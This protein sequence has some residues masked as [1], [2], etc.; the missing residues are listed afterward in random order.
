MHGITDDANDNKNNEEEE[1]YH[2]WSSRLETSMSVPLH[3]GSLLASA[4]WAVHP[5]RAEVI[6]W[7][8]CQPY[9]LAGTWVLLGAFSY[10]QWL[11]RVLLTPIP[12]EQQGRSGGAALEAKG[13]FSLLS[14]IGL[15]VPLVC[16]AAAV[17]SKAAALPFPAMLVA[18]DFALAPLPL[19]SEGS[20]ILMHPSQSHPSRR[21]CRR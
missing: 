13:G 9:A 1:E 19:P 17:M 12:L 6:G 3:L 15:S 4:I 7:P 14:W 10:L 11:D 21:R 18:I 2:Q 8:S 16:Y 20:K 5:L